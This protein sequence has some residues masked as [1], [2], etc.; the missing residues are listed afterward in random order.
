MMTD[1]A[2]DLKA[3]VSRLELRVRELEARL[4]VLE[5]YTVPRAEHPSDDA[6][7]RRKVSYDWQT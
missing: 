7:I 1:D 5:R 3:Q 2:N 6:A 4:E